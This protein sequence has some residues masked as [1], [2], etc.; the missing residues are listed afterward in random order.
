VSR[1]TESILIL[2]DRGRDLNFVGGLFSSPSFLARIFRIH[3]LSGPRRITSTMR[4][5]RFI[6]S[7]VMAAAVVQA[8]LSTANHDKRGVSEYRNRNVRVTPLSSREVKRKPQ[9]EDKKGR[10]EK[11]MTTKKGKG[12][13]GGFTLQLLHS[14]DNLSQLVDLNTMEEKVIHYANL[15]QGLKELAGDDTYTLHLT[16]GGHTLPGVFNAASAEVPYLGKPG[17]ADILIYNAMNLNA[18]AL[19]NSEFDNGMDL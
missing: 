4:L 19:G 7:W 9:S 12:K 10:K 15:V 11:K 1:F 17:L 18:N 14:S 2:D 3:R 5:A 6:L 16:A 13:K 8:K